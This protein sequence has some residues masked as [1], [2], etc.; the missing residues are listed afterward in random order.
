VTDWRTHVGRELVALDRLISENFSAH[1]RLYSSKAIR[2]AMD[3]AKAAWCADDY[4]HAAY[5]AKVVTA[6]IRREAPIFGG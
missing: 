4:N 6:M 3:E 1:G 2:G 5:L